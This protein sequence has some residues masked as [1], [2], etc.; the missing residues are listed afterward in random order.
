ML[1]IVVLLS[2]PHRLGMLDAAL[3]S[4][5]LDSAQLS[6]VHITHPG[7]RWD[8]GAGLRERFE[9]H[10]K[11]RVIEFPGRLDFA[12]SFNRALD[13]V[14]TPWGLLL[15]D[16]DLLLPHNLAATLQAVA[17]RPQ[18]AGHGFVAGGWYYLKDERYL[19]SWVKQRGLWAALHHAPKLCSTL[20]SMCRVREAGG[21]DATVG[22]FCDTVLFARLAF[23]YD[24]LVTRMPIGIYRQ[25][26]G[27]E[28]A[29][30]E[31]IFGPFVQPLT[32]LL[33][34]YARTVRERDRFEQ[35]LAAYV[36]GRSRPLATLAQKLLYPLRSR[37]RPDDTTPGVEMHSWSSV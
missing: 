21:F 16:D 37:A 17:A 34:R 25:H 9:A 22:G 28:S 35:A 4:I 13:T 33:G 31:Q 30:R 8:W 12:D 6:A 3:S 26:A 18:A 7:G 5:P 1:T 11:V 19:A 27:Q 36:N 14:R 15:P 20:L 24:A 10:P 29:R 32:R 23:E 2:G